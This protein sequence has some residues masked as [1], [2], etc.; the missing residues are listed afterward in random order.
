MH[1]AMIHLCNNGFPPDIRISKEAHALVE[2]GHKITICTKTT[3][4]HS[5]KFE[6]F[7]PG[8]DVMR[9]DVSGPPSWFARRKANFTLREAWVKPVVENYLD[10]CKPDI[11]HV[12]DFPYLP[13]VL[14]C[15]IPR[16]LPVVADFH[17]NMPAAKRAW[18][19][20]LSPYMRFKAS[21][22]FNYT[23]WRWHE[24]AAVEKC[25][26][27]VVV[28][29]EGAE[30]LLK[31]GLDQARIVTVSNTEDTTTFDFPVERADQNILDKYK[32][33][34]MVSYIGGIGPHRGWDTALDGAAHAAKLIPNFHLTFVGTNDESAARIRNYADSLGLGN[35]VEII[36]WQPFDT[37]NSYIHA[38]RV[39]LVPHNDFEH[40]HTTVPHKLFQY[41]ICKRPILASDCRPLKRI[42]EETNSGYLFKAN[43]AAD[44]AAQ[45]A[46]IHSHEE[47]AMHK[48]ENGF[49]AATG[50]Y[51]WKHD[52]T[53]LVETYAALER[54]LV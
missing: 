38:S 35:S 7:E 29:P 42:L 46:H 5:K 33:K 15:A 1:I 25:K 13:L 43:N 8:I 52:A 51:A 2:A 54:E 27:V 10:T 16:G 23:L 48:A 24:K 44:F 50:P 20:H 9:E 4:A 45:L 32:D 37:V 17:E 3:S 11:V 49:A 19:S 34:W 30:R 28:V 12:H 47:E 6:T 14:D 39:C 53:R 40:T 31:Y 21:I 36:N 22:L 26:R 18:R 41:M